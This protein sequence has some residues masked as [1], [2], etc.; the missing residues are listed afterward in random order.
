[1]AR[2][3]LAFAAAALAGAALALAGWAGGLLDG[4]ERASVDARF[5]LRGA[6]PVPA[7]AVVDL[8]D[9]SIRRLGRWPL[10]RTRHA[11]MID[12]LR[13]AGVRAIAYDVQF[14]EASDD[15]DADAALYDAIARTRGVVLATTAVLEDGDTTVFGGRENLDPAGAQA[16][17][18]LLVNDADAAIRRVPDAQDGLPSFSAAV[19]RR[20]M[21]ARFR[22]SGT[23]EEGAWIDFAGPPGTILTIPFS[24]VLDDPAVARRLRGRIVVVGSS[25][26]SL[27]DLHAT[28][29]SGRLMPGPEI[30]ANAIATAL[31]GYPLR[32]APWGAG[33]LAVL[34]GAAATAAAFALA[35]L[36]WAL[37]TGAGAVLAWA[38]G[39][40]LAF[41]AGWVVPVSAPVA[42]VALTALGGVAVSFVRESRERRRVRAVFSR[43]VPEAVVDE[44]LA[45]AGGELRLGGVR[46]EATV[47]FCD[48]RGFTAFA[49]RRPAEVVI[50]VLNRYLSEMSE[51]ILDHGGTLVSYM[52][53]GIMAVFGSPLERPDHADAAVAAARE[54]LEVRLG[55][56]NASLA[57]DGID[58]VFR[59]GIGLNSGTVMSGN[60]GSERRLEYAAIGDTTNVAA[61]LE[62]MTKG[63]PHQLYASEATVAAL[64]VPS[65][66]VAV[67]EAE[68]RGRAE[69]VRLWSLATAADGPP[70]TGRLPGRDHVA[71]VAP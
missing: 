20:V 45:A 62:S 5:E 21:G 63:T 22:P 36:R 37:A 26:P 35:R 33:A 17:S 58:V 29:A 9:A 43:F 30:Q 15:P 60:V 34:L 8:D 55:R 51:A 42:A 23:G 7:L 53:D 3:S 64:T 66:L 57:A 47:M 65:G 1:V 46:R 68:I 12:R 18:A 54:M 13:S 2:S 16:A 59:M 70:A 31:A 24:R 25:A 69:T 28:S 32:S 4:V 49:E 38:G 39:A 10:P 61:R 41:G 11:R 71:E 6:R 40:Q 52:G 67:G 44:V 14:T 48:L 19:A 56:F 50:E 27:Q